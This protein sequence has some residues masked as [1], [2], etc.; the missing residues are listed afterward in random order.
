LNLRT[1]A[2]FNYIFTLLFTVIF[3]TLGLVHLLVYQDVPLVRNSLVY[4]N[5]IKNILE[6]KEDFN[7][8]ADAYNKP[9]G[10]AYFSVPFVELFNF[11]FGLKV[12]SFVTTSLWVM[13]LTIFFKRFAQHFS[14]SQ[15]QS[16]L[17]FILTLL[18][19]LVFY[20][21]ISAYPDTFF[22]LSFVWS[23][24]F[25]D[26]VFSKDIKWFDG[27]AVGILLVFSTWV[28]HNGL[29]LVP[30]I[31]MFLFSRMGVFLNL[32]KDRKLGVL[33]FIFCTSLGT[34]FILLVQ[35]GILELNLFN[36]GQ[37]TSNYTGGEDRVDIILTNLGN[38][39]LYFMITL[40]I[41]IPF[42][43]LPSSWKI[44]RAILLTIAIS[45]LSLLFYRGT[46]YNLRYYITLTPFFTL[47]VIKGI[48][49]FFGTLKAKNNDSFSKSSGGWFYIKNNGFNVL[50][51]LFFIV[52]IFITSYYNSIS[53]NSWFQNIFSLPSQDNLRLAGEQREA[54]EDIKT[55]NRLSEEG[56]D[57]LIFISNYYTD[58]EWYIWEESGLFKI[59]S[60]KYF[61]NF[62]DINYSAADSSAIFYS[63]GHLPAEIVNCSIV[64]HDGRVY[65]CQ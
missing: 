57:H 21:F 49:H 41:F 30:V 25:L 15:N 11:N 58:A 4:A 38:L 35:F 24:Y 54:M 12:S 48:N 1:P 28:K 9:L 18:N 42:I 22:A 61:N 16:L 64:E 34:L 2:K 13:S 14:V 45:V 65:T 33:A 44:D 8:I 20:Q 56:Y 53:F 26:R 19:P 59:K 62:S 37:N 7:S 43:F 60:I 29:V 32:L 17:F 39:F 3:I 51:S 23:V 55:I 6:L 47:V 52:N 5:I 10:F 46:S 27:V 40:G 63:R 36:L 31:L 50:L